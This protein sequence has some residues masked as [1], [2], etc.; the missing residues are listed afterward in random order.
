MAHFTAVI[1]AAGKGTRMKSERPKVL[2]RL[3]GTTM[4]EHVLRTV[5]QLSI[6]QILTIV[7]HGRDRVIEEI[8][9]R[10][11]WVLQE[12]QLGTGHALI[13]AA[14]KIQDQTTVLV[15]SGDQPLLTV[16]TMQALIDQH[17]VTGATA[18]VL[19]A[20]LEDPYGYGRILKEDGKF[21]GI[22][23]E[24]D[25][26]GEQKKIKE[27]NTGTY[28]FQGESLKKALQKISAKNAQGEYYLT[29]VFAV[30]LAEKKLIATYCMEDA[31]E[32]MG[33]NHR[34]QLAEAEEILYARIRQQW[35]MEGVTM[36][37]PSSIFI[38]ATAK[39]EKDATILPFTFIKG[40]CVVE[41]G[42]VIGPGTTLVDCICEK[43]CTIEYSVARQAKIGP[44]CTIGPYAYIRPGT[45]LGKGV[46]VGDF[47]E[48]KNSQIGDGSKIPH[49]SYIGDAQLGRNVNIGAGTITCNYDGKHKHQSLI[50]DDSF[51]GSNSNLV[52]PV[53]IGSKSYVG[54]GST[55]TKDVPDQALAVER[56]QQKIV[57]NWQ[58][59][60]DK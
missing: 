13:Q 36:T 19:T 38:D 37:H 7:G 56:A 31:Q 18:T 33:I 4:L 49:L 8:Q 51:I 57:E 3:A 45:I 5:E 10:T 54:A 28:C 32:A 16:Q 12:E 59:A 41:E 25:A 55:V 17:E 48:V 11:D 47:V 9:G 30:L 6:Q 27:I 1:L 22:V 43:G 15:C 58:S 2:H 52:A 21:V 34:G 20:R 24:K 29:D 46:K 39:L 14:S 60:K 35:M 44:D 23:E 50:G 53:R 26:S 40:Q 42:A